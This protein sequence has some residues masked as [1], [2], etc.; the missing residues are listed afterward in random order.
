M[1]AV[2]T[3]NVYVEYADSAFTHSWFTSS[4]KAI[5]LFYFIIIYFLGPHLWH[6]EVPRLGVKLEL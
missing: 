3:T 5:C 1:L 6:M 2:F 4:N